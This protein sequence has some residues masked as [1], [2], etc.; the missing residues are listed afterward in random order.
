M[1]ARI[2]LFL[3]ASLSIK[4]I[5]S[6]LVALVGTQVLAMLGEI[7]LSQVLVV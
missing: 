6:S 1:I 2:R 4:V 5:G 3:D 7:S